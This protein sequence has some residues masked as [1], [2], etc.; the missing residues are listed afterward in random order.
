MYEEEVLCL[1]CLINLPYTNF[2]LEPEN[3][4]LKQFWGTS[5]IESA[6][7][8]LYFQQG[9]K[10]QHLLHQIKYQQNKGAALF[11]G[12]MYGKTLAKTSFSE[13][14]FLISI[15]LHASKLRL[16]GY[17]QSALFS[18]GLQKSMKVPVLDQVLVRE[19]KGESQTAN[20]RMKRYES[21]KGAFSLQ[22]NENIRKRLAGKHI[23]L[24]DD[25]V[26]SGATLENCASLFHEIGC[27]VSVVAMAYTMHQ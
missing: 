7:A 2:H 12:S 27:R 9:S 26:T 3:S 11:L 24:A 14:D 20:N 18:A 10:V 5:Y 22:L 8:C 6:T 17:N 19:Q 23:L 16:R 15:P 21:L 4:L 13:S 1:H 25:V